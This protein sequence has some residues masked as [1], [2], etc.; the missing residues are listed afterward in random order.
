MEGRA[1]CYLRGLCE[2]TCTI[3]HLIDKMSVCG[4]VCVSVRG[5]R[6]RQNPKSGWRERDKGEKVGEEMLT[7]SV[8]DSCHENESAVCQPTTHR[9]TH[10]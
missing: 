4:C 6:E 9:H 10:K 7:V 8:T 5:L 3:G 1:G 2:T